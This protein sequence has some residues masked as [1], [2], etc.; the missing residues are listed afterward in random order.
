MKK[1][2]SYPIVFYACRW[3]IGECLNAM[4]DCPDQFLWK[5]WSTATSTELVHPKCMPTSQSHLQALGLPSGQA[6]WKTTSTPIWAP[7]QL[8]II[9]I[10]VVGPA[11]NRLHGSTTI[12]HHEEFVKCD[13]RMNYKYT[14][15]KWATEIINLTITKIAL[16]NCQHGCQQVRHC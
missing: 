14:T 7:I 3:T 8:S 9:F 5:E 12:Q 6:R 11:C 15:T 13:K 10:Q 1:I 16:N 2:N 4:P